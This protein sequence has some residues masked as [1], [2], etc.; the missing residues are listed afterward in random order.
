MRVKP[1]IMIPLLLALVLG[2]HC[3][4][5]IVYPQAPEG[6]R[7]IVVHN[8]DPHF[9]GVSSAADLIIAAPCR[10]YYVGLTNLAAGQ[11]LSA[12]SDGQ[13]AYLLLQGTNAAGMIELMVGKT[14]EKTLEFAGLYKSNFSNETLTAMRT[15]QQWPLIQKEDYEVRRLECPS[16]TFVAVWL[17]GKSDDLI[18]P[19]PPTFGR[20]KAY[21]PYSESEILKTLE[22]EAKAQLAPGF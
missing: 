11:L 3:Q 12:A 2:G 16:V 1:G 14:D 7:Q 8:L 9:L 15:A 10:I 20:W 17:H 18:I 22:A 19:L 6:G 5:A 4:A 21:Q 13:W